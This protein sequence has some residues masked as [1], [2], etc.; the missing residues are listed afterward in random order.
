MT[1]Q[2]QPALRFLSLNVDGLRS[3]GK[4]RSLFTLLQCDRLDVVLVRRRITQTMLRDRHGLRAN[5]SGPSYWSHGSTTSRGV[6]V[7]FGLGADIADI[8]MRHQSAD[9]RTLSMDFT[10]AG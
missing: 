9:G 10:F 3:T 6:A 5:W 4:R 2:R 7:L 1:Q 8:T